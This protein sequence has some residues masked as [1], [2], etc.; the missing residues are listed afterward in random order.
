MKRRLLLLFTLLMCCVFT[1]NAQSI[2]IGANAPEFSLQL[3]VDGKPSTEIVKLSDYKG[4]ALFLHFWATW[5]PPCKV[6]LPHMEK[7]SQKI[8]AKGNDSKIEFLAIC[9]SDS[10]KAFSSFMEKNKYTF[11][12]GLDSSGYIAI[13]YGIQGIPTSIL[14]SPEGKI[15]KINV[16]MMNEKQLEK[17]IGGYDI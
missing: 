5:C 7:L 14:I 12:G 16:G 10:Q 13:K 1:L 9:I 4:K 15:L 3:Q 17:F 8:Q 2:N 11:T 6:E